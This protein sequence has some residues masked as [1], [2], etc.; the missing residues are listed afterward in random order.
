MITLRPCHERG[1]FNHGWLDT[2]HTFSFADYYDVHHMGF[3]ALRVINE[4]RIAPG[5][6]FG[7]HPHQEMEIIT[8][9][10]EGA[11]AH[12]D[13]MGNGS[14]IYPGDVQRMSAGT[15]VTH[16]EFNHSASEAVHLLQIWILPETRGRT[17]SYEQQSFTTEERQGQLCL[18]ASKAPKGKAVTIHQDVHVFASMLSRGETLS[19]PLAKDRHAWAQVISGA[20][21]V[22]DIPLA[23]GDGAA[24]SEEA[25]LTFKAQTDA[26]FLLFDLQ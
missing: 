13:S 7:T 11:L 19:Y 22:N 18:V 20:L 4:D 3:Q 1:H 12:R 24:I 10:L 25:A 26:H 14:V 21:D 8:Y 5:K 16:S 6:G 9:V 17:P 23:Q 2:Y 15:G